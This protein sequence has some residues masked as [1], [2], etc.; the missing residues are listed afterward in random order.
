MRFL[1]KL[2]R[3]LQKKYFPNE[4]DLSMRRWKADQGDQKLRLEYDLNANSVVLD[5]GGYRGDWAHDIHSLYGCTVH[6]FEPVAIFANGIEKRFEGNSAIHVHCCGLGRTTR[7]EQLGLSADASSMFQNEGDL[8]TIQLVDVVDWFLK[9]QIRRVDLMKI[10]I[11]GGEYEL[12]ER[13]LESGLASRI[14]NI[15]V[16]F[17]NIADDSESRM[18][19]ILQQMRATH[20]PTYQYHFVWENWQRNAA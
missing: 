5:L 4:R 2:R 1:I 10:N 3:S 7:K 18:Q 17:H 19:A 11:E 9:N 20:Q 6:V 12:L 16:Q 13:L 15:Q 14:E 8:E